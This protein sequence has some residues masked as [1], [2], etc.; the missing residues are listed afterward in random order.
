MTEEAL[1]AKKSTK[2]FVVVACIVVILILVFIFGMKKE[3]PPSVNVV[4]YNYFKFEEIGGLWQTR[5]QLDN[6]VYEGAFRFNPEQ[7]EDV[8]IAG[9]FSGFK[10]PI[11]ITFDPDSEESEFKYLALASSELSLHVVRGLNFT[12]VGACTKNETDACLDRPIVT[13]DDTNESVIYL[14]A[15]PPTQITLDG[16]C[17]KLSGLEMDLLKSVD[18]LL[19]QWYKIMK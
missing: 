15:E 19:F 11:Y 8:Y 5:I 13:C 7:V 1:D 9:E 17:V 3:A 2:T 12:V 10:S 6:Q 4:E 16:K 14:V 18:R